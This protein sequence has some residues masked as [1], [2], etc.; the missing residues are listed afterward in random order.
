MSLRKIDIVESVYE[1][2]DIPK[3]ECTRIVESLFEIV[4]ED[5]GNGNDVLISG[6]GKWVV[7][8]KKERRGRNPQTGNDL[9][10]DARKTVTFKPS[11][12]LK[13]ALNRP[14]NGER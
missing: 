3:N 7:R 10:I 11:P 8:A 1:R 2:L 5:L 6:F 12:Q 4:K 13:Q 9:T 14:E